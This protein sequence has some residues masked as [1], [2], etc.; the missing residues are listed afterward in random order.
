MTS[1]FFPSGEKA[2]EEKPVWSVSAFHSVLVGGGDAFGGPGEATA[3]WTRGGT[4]EVR[5]GLLEGSRGVCMGRE[6]QRS[7]G[8]S[9][10]V[11]SG[12]GVCVVGVEV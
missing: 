3:K 10:W 6:W 5:R 9:V 12:T 2:A 11:G 1:G 7:R 8:G 4:T